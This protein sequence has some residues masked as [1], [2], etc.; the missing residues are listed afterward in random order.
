MTTEIT[1]TKNE[2]TQS[3]KFTEK[4]LAEFTG[5]VGEIAV[6]D[7][8]KRLI[9]GYFITIDAVLK[10]AEAKR[11]KTDENKLEYEWKNVN[12]TLLAQTAVH[13]ARL[14][15]DSLCPNHVFFI[16]YKNNLTGKYDINV[17]EGYKGKEIKAVK[18]G[19]DIPYNIVFEL[20]YDSDLFIPLKKSIKNKIE[21]YEFEI[22]NPFDRG[23]LIGGFAY[24]D[25]SDLNKNSLM[26]MS[27]KDIEKRK[28]EKAS[29]EFW[30]GE[31]DVWK[32]GKKTKDKQKV[33]GWLEEMCLKTIKRAAYSQ[34]TIDS[35]RIDDTYQF[36]KQRENDTIDTR[37]QDVIEENANS[38]VIDILCEVKTSDA[39][40]EV[41]PEQ[42]RK[43]EF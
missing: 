2:L 8:Q 20:V 7:F 40:Q 24:F 43:P 12:M 4:V 41:E 15:L 29:S 28:P 22:K 33:D 37:V 14:G 31:K 18:Y 36:L 10:K 32:D 19:L 13:V 21:S 42:E 1:T 11:K 38:E 39:K 27:L 3:Q 17:M 25:H 34:I 30:G 5:G 23:N 16:P 26:M 35:Q 6:T 9:Q